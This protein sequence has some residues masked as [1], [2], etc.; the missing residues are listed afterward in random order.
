M[1]LFYKEDLPQT[2][3]PAYTEENNPVCMCFA[4]NDK[5]APYLMVAL[6]SLLVNADDNRCYDILIM[7]KDISAEH[8]ESIQQLNK[9]RN[10]VSIRFLGMKALDDT[11]NVS[12]DRY[13][14]TETNYRLYLMSE[15]FKEYKKMFYLDTDMIFQGDISELYDTDMKGY[16]IA[17]VQDVMFEAI[18]Q[19]KN[20]L[21]YHD[22]PY[23]ALGYFQKIIGL[24]SLKQYFNA[25]MIL[26]DLQRMR[27]LSDEK[28]AV[29]IL[30]E[31]KFTYNDQDTLNYIVKGHYLSLDPEWNYQNSFDNIKTMSSEAVKT[32][33]QWLYRD[34]PKIIHYV[35]GRKPWN[36]ERVALDEA[37][38][39]YEHKLR[40][41]RKEYY[42]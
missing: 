6:Y 25:G 39:T 2:I 36:T 41:Y 29:Q 3:T 24:E 5:Y 13:Y 17:A 23:N 16:P 26:L 20:P 12:I 42:Q 14:S 27:E 11:V 9:L 7:T 22:V 33:F 19:K 28:R 35:S 31:Y 10:M 37:Y 32:Q 15:H 38:H 8:R 40:E 18:Y 1:D 21:F 30:N 4:A 34:N